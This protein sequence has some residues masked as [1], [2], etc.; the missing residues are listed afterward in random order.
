[1]TLAREK[2]LTADEFFD[3][4]DDGRSLELVNGEVVEMTDGGGLHGYVGKS[5]YN[6]LDDFVRAHA[7]GVVPLSGTGFRLAPGTVRK[8]DAGFVPASQWIDPPP[9]KWLPYAPALAV[10]IVSPSDRMAE[11]EAKAQEYL[12]AGTREVWVVSPF[13][14]TVQVWRAG[15][16][17]LLLK[18]DDRLE[19]PEL[20]PGFS[21]RV[22]DFFA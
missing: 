7:L 16:S 21:A 15:G 3:L 13:S 10:E 11:V 5:V 22:G 1:M 2:K 20:L 14:K 12:D 6:A 18:G 8:P 17:V 9:V 19:S 4:E